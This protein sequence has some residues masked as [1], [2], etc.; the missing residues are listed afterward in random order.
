M[1]SNHIYLKTRKQKYFYFSDI[2]IL[3]FSTTGKNDTNLTHRK[4]KFLIFIEIITQLY[5]HGYVIISVS[6]I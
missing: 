3:F 2:F 6:Y 4:Q 1:F 5:T